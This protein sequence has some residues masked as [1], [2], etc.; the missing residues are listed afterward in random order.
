MTVL[1]GSVLANQCGVWEGRNTVCTL[2][3]APP[4]FM[5]CSTGTRLVVMSVQMN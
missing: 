3:E 2:F 4:V 1:I 5:F